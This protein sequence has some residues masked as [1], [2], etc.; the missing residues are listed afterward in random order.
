MI[1]SKENRISRLEEKRAASDQKND[2]CGCHCHK[3]SILDFHVLSDKRITAIGE[4][5]STLAPTYSADCR[6]RKE[7]R[8]KCG[9][10]H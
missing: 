4:L 7:N 10:S 1:G 2:Y 3:K 6:K 5:I 8:Q 9:C